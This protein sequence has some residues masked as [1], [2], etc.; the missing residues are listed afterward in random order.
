MLYTRSRRVGPIA[1]NWVA[2]ATWNTKTGRLVRWDWDHLA[3]PAGS[4]SR[5]GT[6]AAVSGWCSRC[7]LGNTPCLW[8]PSSLAITHF[9]CAKCEVRRAI[10]SD[11]ATDRVSEAASNWRVKW[12]LPVESDQGSYLKSFTSIFGSNWFN[13]VSGLIFISIY[14]TFLS[15]NLASKEWENRAESLVYSLVALVHNLCIIL[16]STCSSSL[17]YSPVFFYFWQ[18]IVTAIGSFQSLSFRPSRFVSFSGGGES[19][20]IQNCWVLISLYSLLWLDLCFISLFIDFWR[21]MG[22]NVFFGSN[23]YHNLWFSLFNRLST[24][25]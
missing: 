14:S 2:S 10:A 3:I 1:D 6:A 25:T 11:R 22:K 9:L 7:N 8:S 4:W 15:L 17:R 23:W 5:T 24:S 12:D 18:G 21:E 19:R 13:V 16:I 20:R